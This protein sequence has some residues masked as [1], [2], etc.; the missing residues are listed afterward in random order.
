MYM[1]NKSYIQSKVVFY[2]DNDYS[3]PR[4]RHSVITLI[5]NGNT[6]SFSY[7]LRP[8]TNLK[9]RH[10]DYGACFSVGPMSWHKVMKL[11]GISASFTD[12]M[13]RVSNGF[14]VLARPDLCPK[15]YHKIRLSSQWLVNDDGL[16]IV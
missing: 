11:Q 15:T 1:R 8:G 13:N 5:L 7:L 3:F 14:W 10:L 16:G 6:T 2:D 4:S 12:V 9:H